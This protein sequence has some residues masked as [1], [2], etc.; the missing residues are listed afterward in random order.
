MQRYRRLS[1]P[2]QFLSLG[3]RIR[4]RERLSKRLTL[5]LARAHVLPFP[6]SGADRRPR[7]NLALQ[8]DNHPARVAPKEALEDEAGHVERWFRCQFVRDH[9]M[10]V[11]AREAP[12]ALVP[13]EGLAATVMEDQRVGLF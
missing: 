2:W 13:D 3:D 9:R 12:G 7:G 11:L 5:C 4:D 1:I 10:S 8:A 6:T